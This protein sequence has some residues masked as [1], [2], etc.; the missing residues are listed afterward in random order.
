M[1]SFFVNEFHADWRNGIGRAKFDIFFDFPPYFR[2][3]IED[4]VLKSIAVAIVDDGDL[5]IF[6]VKVIKLI[7]IEMLMQILECASFNF[8]IMFYKLYL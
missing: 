1:H 4:V 7:F 8:N 5:L 6:E 2:V 3:S